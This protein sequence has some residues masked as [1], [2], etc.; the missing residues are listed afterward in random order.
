MPASGAST[1]RFSSSSGP[2]FQVSVRAGTGASHGIGQE[3][4]KISDEGVGLGRQLSSCQ[5]DG[6]PVVDLE[7]AV[8]LPIALAGLGGLVGAATVELDDDPPLAPDRVDLEALDEDVDL[9]AREP[10]AIDQ[11]EEAL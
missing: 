6:P 4:L 10:G 9:R 7:C 1:T 2:S 3:A 11:V 5:A 8:A